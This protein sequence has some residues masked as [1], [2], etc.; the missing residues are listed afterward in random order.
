MLSFKLFTD[1][2][3]PEILIIELKWP[4]I[5]IISY[6]FSRMKMSG[7][8]KRFDWS[9]PTDDLSAL[10]QV[11]HWRRMYDKPLTEPVLIPYPCIYSHSHGCWQHI[12]AETKWPQIS[13]RQFQNFKCI[14]LNKNARFFLLKLHLHVLARVQSTRS[15]HCSD[16]DSVP[17][18]RQGI[19]WTND[20]ETIDAYLCHSTSIS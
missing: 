13:C 10:V 2:S 17:T 18:R 8:W 4:P 9:P 19:I 5:Y 3:H 15:R 14:M 12:E 16:D 1:K 20:C 6:M 7:I 11:V